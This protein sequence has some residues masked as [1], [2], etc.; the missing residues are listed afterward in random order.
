MKE[1][2]T[3]ENL[4]NFV[5]MVTFSVPHPFNSKQNIFTSSSPKGAKYD[6][7]CLWQVYAFLNQVWL[8]RFENFSLIANYSHLYELL[9]IELEPRML[10]WQ[11]NFNHFFVCLHSLHLF[12]NFH[13]ILAHNTRITG[14]LNTYR[15]VARF[16][17]SD[18]QSE[19]KIFLGLLGGSGGMLSQKDFKIKD[20]RLAKNAFPEISA[21][22]N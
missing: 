13:L 3:S 15:V 10:P 22:K 20:L 9:F 1:L 7:M 18:P 5:A 4:K 2:E 8:Q 16:L 12:A 11:Q 21:W 17:C 14:N 19:E 6:S